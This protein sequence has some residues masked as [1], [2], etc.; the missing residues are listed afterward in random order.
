MLILINL[1]KIDY[2]F[3]GLPVVMAIDQNIDKYFG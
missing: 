3:K 2:I 1:D